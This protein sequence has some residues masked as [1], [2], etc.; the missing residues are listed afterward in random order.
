MS[1]IASVQLY[2]HRPGLI[3]NI[4][5]V[6]ANAGLIKTI[7]NNYEQPHRGKQHNLLSSSIRLAYYSL[8][9]IIG[10]WI[11]VRKHIF[12][13]G[14]VLF[15]RY[16]TDMIVD[17]RRSSIYLP[18]SLLYYWGKIFIPQLKYNILLTADSDVILSRKRELDTNSINEINKKIDYLSNKKRYKKV[19]NNGSPSDTIYQILRSILTK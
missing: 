18:P 11:L 14:F 6:A 15:D 4:S 8:D 19:I 2:H 12:Y 1:D 9:Y 7:D 10:Y 5:N 17:S 3:G 16:Y 13:G